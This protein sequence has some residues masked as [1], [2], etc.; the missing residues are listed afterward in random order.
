ME[1]RR[2]GKCCKNGDFWRGSSYPDIKSFA[3]S[4][5]LYQDRDE[6]HIDS[7]D[8]LMLK[9]EGEMAVCLIEK[10]LGREFKPQVC[11]DYPVGVTDNNKCKNNRG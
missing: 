9:F 6:D 2:C 10:H 11:K 1:C 8:C 3:T 4:M 7:G 5:G